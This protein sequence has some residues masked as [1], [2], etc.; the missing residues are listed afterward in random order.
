MTLAPKP[1]L[2]GEDNPYGRDDPRFADPHY[3]LYPL[4]A[5][6]AGGRLCRVI[7]QMQMTEYM[8]AFDRVNLCATVWSMTEARASAVR[9]VAEP[10]R[11]AI[12]L[13]GSKV[14]SAFGV[15]FAPFEIVALAPKSPDGAVRRLVV[16]P[17]P[18]GRSMVWNTPGAIERARDT[19]RAV[20]VLPPISGPPI[21]VYPPTGGAR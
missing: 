20:G 15:D 9:I 19:L 12:V 11:P 14:C 10:P 8:R 1:L 6:S 16:L 21:P 17:H 3:A 4:P 5:H 13:F 18:S 7:M 2:V